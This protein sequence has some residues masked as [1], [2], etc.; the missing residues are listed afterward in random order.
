[1]PTI[2]AWK[3]AAVVYSLSFMVHTNLWDIAGN[4]ALED[5][6]EAGYAELNPI[7]IFKAS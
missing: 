1:M 3:T 6:Y 4:Q 7:F 2:S 5:N